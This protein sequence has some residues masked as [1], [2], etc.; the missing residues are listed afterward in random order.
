MVKKGDRVKVIEIDD[1]DI[2]N[3]VASGDEGIALDSGVDART[4]ILIEF[5][6]DGRRH[7][8][9]VKQLEIIN[10]GITLNK[11]EYPILDQDN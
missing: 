2:K 6:R 4:M 5:D 8:V 3:G 7:N 9:Y 11:D 1:D 10:K